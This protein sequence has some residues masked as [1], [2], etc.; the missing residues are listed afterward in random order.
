[1]QPG[2]LLLK[3]IKFPVVQFQLFNLLPSPFT[4]IF[5]VLY[6]VQWLSLYCQTDA[7]AVMYLHCYPKSCN[8]RTRSLCHPILL[9]FTTSFC[10]FSCKHFT[11]APKLRVTLQFFSFL[12]FCLF[13]NWDF[14]LWIF[15]HTFIPTDIMHIFLVK[16]RKQLEKS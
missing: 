3:R 12:Y 5:L 13:P 11:S 15:L 4:G 16:C 8:Q 2:L 9:W 1:M 6:R 7:T 14:L 10:F